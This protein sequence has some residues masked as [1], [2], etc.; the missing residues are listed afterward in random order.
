MAKISLQ[1]LGCSKN[2][3]DGERILNL[4]V[5]GGHQL[6]EDCKVADIIIVNTCAFIKEAQEEAIE[7]ILE[8][9][10]FRTGGKCSKLVVSGCFSQ[11]FREQVAREF[12]EVD[13]WAGVEDWEKVLSPLL[14]KPSEASFKRQLY[15]PVATQHL[16]IAEGCSHRCSF[17]VIPSI[18]GN[19]KSREPQSIIQEAKWLYEM[20]TRE[21]IIVAQDTSFYG[22]DKGSTLVD[23]LQ[24]LLKE[25]DF[26]W[27]RMMY[28]HPQYVT[29][30]LLELVAGESRIC[31]YFDI[32]L[33]HISDPILKSM[34]RKPLSKDL[35]R[36]VKRIRN[37]V[38]Q[39]GIRSSF[40]LGY[41][42]ES[43]KEY[44]ELV[45]FIEFA[46]FDKLGVFPF[47]PEE[48]TEANRLKPRPDTSIAQKRC[49][50][51]MTIQRDISRELLEARIGTEMEII[52][53]RISDD[54]DFNYEARTRL[55]APEVDG[56]VFI[57]SGSFEPGSIV[58]AKI[59][60]AA[61]YDLYAEV[62]K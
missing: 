13:L 33:Q 10:S 28:L 27:I 19:Y 25:T 51:L 18:R 23:L 8:M 57:S 59:I 16:K 21:L 58:T 40:I 62:I 2:L 4:L 50:E 60:G 45:D 7:T 48:G 54:P 49:E 29:D 12:P 5:S 61:D 46:Q 39:A 55:D 9:G 56:T 34:N 30:E 52:I 53:D 42:G 38:P 22:K 6:T 11:R 24:K 37:T 36:L 35:Y 1:N 20:G 43:D 32:P 3:I 47:S 41:P 31:S 44:N 26:P 17:C 14:E 15:E